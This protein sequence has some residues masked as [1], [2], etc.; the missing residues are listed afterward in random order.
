VNVP[1]K[2]TNCTI[3]NPVTVLNSLQ[4]A[5]TIISLAAT[6]LTFVGSL[7]MGPGTFLLLNT[8]ALI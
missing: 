5:A 8:I 1:D 2:P 6:A 7:S 4:Q 3:N